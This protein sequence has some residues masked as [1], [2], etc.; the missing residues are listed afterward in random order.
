[1]QAPSDSNGNKCTSTCETVPSPA[2]SHSLF[3]RGNGRSNSSRSNP[4]TRRMNC[5]GFRQ[6]GHLRRMSMPQSSLFGPQEVANKSY[7]SMG[8][9]EITIAKA[10][11]T[12][13]S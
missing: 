2:R 10:G 11:F 12:S 1:M 5:D 7:T 4:G 13:L 9:H 6:R 3:D 8:N